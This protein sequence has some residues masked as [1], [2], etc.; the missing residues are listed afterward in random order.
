MGEDAVSGAEDDDERHVSFLF[1]V[2]PDSDT[3]LDFF[4]EP[5]S[6][7]RIGA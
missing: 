7:Y 1:L 4:V 2:A 5:R 6:R 3:I